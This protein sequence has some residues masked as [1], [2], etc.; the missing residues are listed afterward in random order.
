LISSTLSV[1]FL[2][3]TLFLFLPLFLS[4]VSCPLLS[5]NLAVFIY[6]FFISLIILLFHVYNFFLSR[7]FSVISFNLSLYI[8]F[9]LFLLLY[10]L[11]SLCLHPSFNL[12]P[13]YNITFL[14]FPPVSS[15]L[16]IRLILCLIFP[17]YPISFSFPI[18]FSPFA[19]ITSLTQGHKN[20]Y[21]FL[22][23]S[24]II[25]SMRQLKSWGPYILRVVSNKIFHNSINSDQNIFGHI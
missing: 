2:S 14:H 18:S 3:F 20:W 4:S 7:S 25:F 6:L 15:I 12:S 21:F 23:P 9:T 19:I 10:L 13:Y 17:F 24:F 1:L 22:S 11:F 16:Y 8:S 5:L